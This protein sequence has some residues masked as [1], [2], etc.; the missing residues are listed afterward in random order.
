VSGRCGSVQESVRPPEFVSLSEQVDTSTPMGKMVFT[1]IHGIGR[2]RGT[3]TLADRGTREGWS[4]QRSCERQA[5]GS[6]EGFG[7]RSEDLGVA[8]GRSDV[9][10]HCYALQRV[11]DHRNQGLELA[12]AALS[13]SSGFRDCPAPPLTSCY[14]A[15]S[16]PGALA[17]DK[18]KS[19]VGT[20]EGKTANGRLVTARYQLTAGN[21][22]VLTHYCGVGNQPR[23]EATIS[24]DGR[25]FDFRFVGGTN[26]QALETG[27][28]H[29]SVFKLVDSDHYNEDWTWMEDGKSVTEHFVMQRK[30]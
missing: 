5:I 10:G 28:M 25:T 18:M 26:I 1:V 6:A 30:Q 7:F 2:C 23:M 8:R 12:I 20:W 21:S 16:T 9:A 29:R 15:A 22:L 11:E 24:R 4:P 14:V 27:H 3:R 13:D 19:L 17:L